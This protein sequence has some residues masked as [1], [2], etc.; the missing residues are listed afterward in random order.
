MGRRAELHDVGG[1]RITVAEAAARLS[2]SPQALHLQM[3]KRGIELGAAVDLYRS[4]RIAAGQRRPPG[5]HCVHGEWITVREAARRAGTTYSAIVCRRSIYGETLEAAY[6]HYC[7][8]RDGAIPAAQGRKPKRQA[9]RGRMVTVA[10]AAA[11]LGVTPGAL[12]SYMSYHSVSL[13]EAVRAA[14]ARQKDAAVKAILAILAEG[15]G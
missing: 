15:R 14:E 3:R 5:L 10:E 1:E 12:R 4:G 11:R 7:M 2:V 9:V 8:L 6:D 13:A